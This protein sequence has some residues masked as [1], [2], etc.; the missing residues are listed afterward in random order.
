[1]R[2]SSVLPRTRASAVK[3]GG[4]GRTRRW[5]Q[6]GAPVWPRAKVLFTYFYLTTACIAHTL[7]QAPHWLNQVKR[8]SPCG[9]PGVAPT[10]E[11]RQLGHGL[12]I[13][14][15]IT[16]L[17]GKL[18]FPLPAPQP[19][20]SGSPVPAFPSHCLLPP[21]VLSLS[22]LSPY[23]GGGGA[24]VMFPPRLGTRMRTEG[25]NLSGTCSPEPPAR[26][27]GL[28]AAAPSG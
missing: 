14:P 23:T 28:T 25:G 13:V 2:Y 17:E 9:S 10:S 21:R 12:R 1:M 7:C 15:S 22:L 8:L 6:C 19:P 4:S 24:L 3:T 26:R 5:C 18:G 16:Q 27:A 11:K 20:T